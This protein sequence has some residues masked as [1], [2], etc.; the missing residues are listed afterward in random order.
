MFKVTISKR[1]VVNNVETQQIKS[2]PVLENWYTKGQLFHC[3]FSK[4]SDNDLKKHSLSD[5]DRT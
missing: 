1:Y 2:F 4:T 3:V 5:K